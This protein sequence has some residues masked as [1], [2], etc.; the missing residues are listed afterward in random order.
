[1]HMDK[2]LPP[3]AVAAL[4][5]GMLGAALP[6]TASAH[7]ALVDPP[8][9]TTDQKEGPCGQAGSTRGANVTVLEPG[10]TI[11]VRWNETIN[12]TAH[13][14]IAFDVDGNDDFVPPSGRDDLNNSPAVLADG[15]AD[16]RGGSYTYQVTLPDVECENCTLQLI[17]VMYEGGNYFQCA[18]IALRRGGGDAG[19]QTDAGGGSD[20]G[21]AGD[22]GT[23]INPTRGDDGGCSVAAFP[24][25]RTLPWA[26][27]ALLG[28]W[29]YRRRSR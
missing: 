21:S 25:E 7:I 19:V 6:N 4:M 27:I 24:G 20:A 16:M 28:T 3:L 22:G 17:Q 12:H 26:W 8:P 5:S 1:M 14:R 13:Y 23:M 2:T 9:R 18:D 11:T 29:A 15:I 10:A